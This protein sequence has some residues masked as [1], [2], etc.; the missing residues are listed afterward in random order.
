MNAPTFSVIIPA[1]NATNTLR[2]TIESVLGQT[3]EDFEVVV[4]DDGSSD[5]TV[6][7][8]LGMAAEDPRV[9][10]VSQSNE[11]VSSARNFGAELAKGRLLAFLDA[12]DQWSPEKLARHKALH[13]ADPLL[14]ASFAQVE[15]CADE[16]GAMA[17]GRTASR[18]PQGYLDIADVVTENPVCTASNFV[19]DREVFQDLGG[20]SVQ[21]RYAEDHEILA[22]LLSEGGTLRGIEAPL[23]RYRLSEGGLSCD[24][25]AMLEG[26]RSFA[27]NWLSE[28]DLAHA[29]ATY[30]RYLTRR[31]LRSGAGIEVARSFA[32]RGLEA[33][34]AGFMA[35][36]ARSI[37]TLG[38]V[39]AGG[40]MP[41]SLR[42]AVFA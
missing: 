18:V 39:I 27:C 22:L 17:A 19:I 4:V 31:A 38:G 37:L 26:W 20:F 3:F 21:M 24:F 28:R 40:V 14:D 16:E 1:Y 10:V 7:V 2:S 36:G 30:C 29:E 15:F 33:D 41:A 34:R 25:E 6:R 8:A 35:G 5:D 13:D 42:R 32:R 9:R 11:G 12:D 23:V